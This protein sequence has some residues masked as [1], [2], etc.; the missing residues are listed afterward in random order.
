M[1]LGFIV[2]SGCKPYDDSRYKDPLFCIENSD[3]VV[4][5]TCCCDAC[6]N[7]YHYK[8]INPNDCKF[9]ICP[10][11]I[12]SGGGCRCSFY[13][14]CTRHPVGSSKDRIACNKISID[15]KRGSKKM[16]H[17]AIK[18]QYEEEENFKVSFECI[19]SSGGS[20]Y[21]KSTIAF[22]YSKTPV[23]IGK[24]QIGDF[25]VELRPELNASLTTYQCII[26]VNSS[27]EAYATKTFYVTVIS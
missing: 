12:C 24:D 4:Q 23:Q 9:A 13:N 16:F 10:T 20:D 18:N 27:Y 2:L 7:R 21:G 25:F 19:N 11:V 6:V 26:N 3:C 15:V 14:K 8:E 1:L 17:Y 5:P 22:N